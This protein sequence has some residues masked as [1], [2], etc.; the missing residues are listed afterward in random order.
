MFRPSSKPSIDVPS[1]CRELT[2]YGS[3]SHQRCPHTAP[4]AAVPRVAVRPLARTHRDAVLLCDHNNNALGWGAVNLDSMYRVRVLQ[5]A[6]EAAAVAASGA[7]PALSYP[8]IV[9]SALLSRASC[10]RVI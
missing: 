3:L 6:A 10:L 8:D 5:T 9:A 2:P 7:E 4:V 1:V